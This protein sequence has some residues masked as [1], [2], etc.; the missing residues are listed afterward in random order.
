[1]TDN[2]GVLS[3]SR[4]DGVFDLRVGGGE[5]GEKRLDEATVI[6]LDNDGKSGKMFELFHILHTLGATGPVTVVEV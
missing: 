1:V 2:D 4:G 6:R 3:G 5:L